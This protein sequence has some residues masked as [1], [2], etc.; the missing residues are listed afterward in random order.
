MR[1]KHGKVVVGLANEMIVLFVFRNRS[2]LFNDYIRS[3]TV[4]LKVPPLVR[5]KVPVIFRRPKR[6]KNVHLSNER[7]QVLIHVAHIALISEDQGLNA[8]PL[9]L[10][11]LG[12]VIVFGFL[13]ND[14]NFGFN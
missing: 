7:L 6:L 11:L 9:N 12:V 5:L 8:F 10:D 1:V 13:N 3:I 4:V 14:I 2:L